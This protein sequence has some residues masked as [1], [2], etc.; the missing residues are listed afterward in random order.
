MTNIEKTINIGPYQ[1][2]ATA[3]TA[4]AIKDH[5]YIDKKLLLRLLDKRS[6]SV[7][8]KAKPTA[9]I[10]GEMIQRTPS[11]RGSLRSVVSKNIAIHRE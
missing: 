10:P 1:Y 2:T 7:V 3:P 9:V 8:P 5:L 4:H 11:R 6:I